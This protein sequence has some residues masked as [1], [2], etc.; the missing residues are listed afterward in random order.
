MLFLILIYLKRYLY[1]D[2]QLQFFLNI[3]ILLLIICFN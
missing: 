3:R 2:R 1:F